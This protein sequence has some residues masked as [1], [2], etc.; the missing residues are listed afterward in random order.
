M[1]EPGAGPSACPLPLDVLPTNFQKHVDPKAPVPLRLMGA[2]ALVPMG[3]KDMATA[4]FMLTFDADET[5]RQTAI[6]NA[7]GLPDRILAVALRDEAADAKVLDYFAAALLEKPEY[8]EMLVLNPS[9]PDDTV[10]RI[11]AAPQERITE[12]VSQ[13]QLRLLRHDPIVRALVTNPATR[14]VTIDNVTDFC[15]RSGLILADLPAFQAARKRV[16]GTSADEAAALLAAAAAQAEEAA[17]EQA[18]EE[19]GASDPSRDAEREDPDKEAAAE[20]KRLTIAQKISKLSIA[21]KIEWAN[22]KGNKEVRTILLRDPN[23]LVQL[24]VIQSPRISEGEIAKVANTRT[25]PGE[26]LQHIYNNRQLTKNYSIKVNLV[27]NP[28]VPVAVAMRFLIL[29]RQSELKG[30]SKNRN[31]SPALQTQAKKLLEKKV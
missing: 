14:P 12:L 10:A 4:L 7:A 17:A 22:K 9:T 16:L 3:P 18:L 30:V 31:I 13:N 15:V 27:N 28:K 5:V 25:A 21:K 11:A 2:K 29:L 24:A 6:K 1:T 23:K 19:M 20:G 26:V 8:L